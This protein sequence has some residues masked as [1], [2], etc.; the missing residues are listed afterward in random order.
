M[1]AEGGGDDVQRQIDDLS[2]RVESN[3]AGMDE[4]LPAPKR[5]SGG[6]MTSRLARPSIER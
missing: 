4:L 3:H 6:P 1:T 5:Q 2:S